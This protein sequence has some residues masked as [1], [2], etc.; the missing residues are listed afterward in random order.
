M[1]LL[2]LF[3]PDFLKVP[4]WAFPLLGEEQKLLSEKEIIILIL[5]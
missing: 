3:C 1:L 4:I 2:E 5:Y